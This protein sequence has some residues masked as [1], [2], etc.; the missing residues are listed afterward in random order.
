MQALRF[1]A[2]FAYLFA[3][4]VFAVGAAASAIPRIQKHAAAPI[5][6]KAAVVIGTLLQVA[7]V[8][9]LTLR[10]GDGPLRPKVWELA[11]VAALA[12]FGAALFAWAFRSTRGAGPDTLV[13]RG[14]YACVRHPM[15][16]AFL[17]ML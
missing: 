3:W 5:R 17:A 6:I 11:A 7:S 1:V 10:L 16:L 12:P 8:S 4:L 9:M 14:A 2:F 15:Y 13:T